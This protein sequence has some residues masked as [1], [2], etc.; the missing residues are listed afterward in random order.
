MATAAENAPSKANKSM[1]WIMFLAFSGL[2]VLAGLASLFLVYNATIGFVYPSSTEQDLA[3]EMAERKPASQGEALY[4]LESMTVNLNGVPSRMMR[5]QLSLA[6]LDEEG[7]EEIM[8]LGGRV[9][10]EV[11]RV[12]SS[13][14]Y[15]EIESLQGK[16]FLK[17]EIV[18]A[19]NTMLKRGVV[20]D[21]YF[22]DFVVQ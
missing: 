2:N 13:K 10:A 17:D 11:A 20:K 1:A 5:V 12:L 3:K 14:N 18:L 7:F 4:T 8:D 6:L 16:L 9:R 15:N 22:T 21:L 19:L